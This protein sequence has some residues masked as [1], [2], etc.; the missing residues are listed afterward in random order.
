LGLD[1][2]VIAHNGALTKHARTLETVA[3]LPLPVAAARRALE[4]GRTLGADAL[5]S[6]DHESLGVL[7]YDHLAG[8]NHAAQLYVNWARRIHGENGTEAVRQVTSLEEFLDHDPVHLAFA[9]GCA[10]MKALQDLLIEEL[11]TTV[12]IFTTTYQKVDFTLLDIVNPKASKGVG[13]AAAAA[14]L[15]VSREE[16]MAVGDN[17]NDLEMLHYAGTGVVMQN[18]E[19]SLH[20]IEGFHA[21]GTNDED[22]VALAV[23]RF[24]LRPEEN[25]P[26][27]HTKQHE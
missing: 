8:E 21:T 13:V 5:L 18:A 20:E 26:R 22:G 16:V 2:P 27:N 12:K 7:V 24:I 25:D 17:L 15:G 23:E 10:K 19:A 4:V 9:G 11:G 6:D 1:L 14:E 3:V